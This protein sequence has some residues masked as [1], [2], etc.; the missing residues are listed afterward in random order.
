MWTYRL[1]EI[2]P[3]LNNEQKQA[4]KQIDDIDLQNTSLLRKKFFPIKT[5]VIL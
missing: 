1:N 5:P 4:V 3:I 2:A